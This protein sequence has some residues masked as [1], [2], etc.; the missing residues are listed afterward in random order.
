MIGR[1]VLAGLSHQ[2]F[3]ILGQAAER[4]E[5]YQL[6]RQTADALGKPLLVVGGPW[7]DNP[8]RKLAGISYH[9]HGDVCVDLAPYACE[10]ASRFVQAD[11]RDLPFAN[12]E[13]GSC[14]NSH[15]LEHL[16]SAEDCAQAWRE[17]H[18][19]ADT[20]FTCLPGK[21][22]IVA[23][24]VPDHYLWVREVSPGVLLVEERVTGNRY[25]VEA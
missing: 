3:V 20:V 7:G 13:F 15:I 23:W 5:K 1:V 6:A 22:S 4:A 24:L 9:G 2:V 21:A 14:F 19:V 10:G 17:L 25:R 11:I 12:R 18:R 16:P 8:F